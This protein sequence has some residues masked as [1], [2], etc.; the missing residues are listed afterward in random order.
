MQG[1]AA[2]NVGTHGTDYFE[3][4][5]LSRGPV[6]WLEDSRLRGQAVTQRLL[7]LIWL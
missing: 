3:S 1:A 5:S 4:K 7:L 6:S 2:S